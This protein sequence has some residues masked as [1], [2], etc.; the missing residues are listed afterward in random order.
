MTTLYKTA[1]GTEIDM[2]ALAKK[3]EHVRASGNAKLNG[4]GDQID[5]NNETVIPKN[6]RVIQTYYQQTKPPI[7]QPPKPP[8]E[9]DSF[10]SLDLLDSE[11]EF[12]ED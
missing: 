1:R 11:R 8:V 10:V 3:F 5:S 7:I 4:R 12:D 9:P 6:Q 2:N